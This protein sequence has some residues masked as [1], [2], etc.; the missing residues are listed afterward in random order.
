M[1][2]N[3]EQVQYKT[4]L[5]RL[6]QETCESTPKNFVSKYYFNP[7]LN[8][9]ILSVSPSSHVDFSF[10][11]LID[12]DVPLILNKIIIEKSC[13]SL[14]L[15]GNRLTFKSMMILGSKSYRNDS[16][17]KLDLS[18]NRLI[19][20]GTKI[21]C[22]LILSNRFTQLK[23][24]KLNK[25]G[26]SNSGAKYLSEILKANKTIEEL[27]LSDNEISNQGLECFVNALTTV[28]QTLKI[29]ILSYNVFITNRCSDN[30]V[31]LLK[32]NNTLQNLSIHRCSITTP[33]QIELERIAKHKRNFHL[34]V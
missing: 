24:V 5:F 30:L 11:S 23:I 3:D 13:T 31:E 28:N 32:K 25:N 14:D 9:T 26:I 19:D 7:K 4:T 15:Y 27:W 18:F 6:S 21:L 10:W 8:K 2:S 33:V 17:Q 29:L 20:N 1:S 22:Q 34:E 12:D 16:L